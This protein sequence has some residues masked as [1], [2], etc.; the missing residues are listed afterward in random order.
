MLVSIL[1]QNPYCC[2]KHITLMI[3]PFPVGAEPVI[4]GGS[5]LKCQHIKGHVPGVILQD[6]VQFISKFFCVLPGHPCYY[7]YGVVYPL[8][9]TEISQ[10][11]DIGTPPGSP[12][13]AMVDGVDGLQ[14]QRDPV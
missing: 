13:K 11:T 14:P 7:V 8:Y 1:T 5:L 4:Q 10:H 3:L 2:L 9:R 6:P 12:D